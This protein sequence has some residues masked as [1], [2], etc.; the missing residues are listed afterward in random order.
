MKD[1][2]TTHETKR[3]VRRHHRLR[4]IEHARFVVRN[5]W[6]FADDEVEHKAPRVHDHLAACSCWMCGNP[7]RYWGERTLQE[8]RIAALPRRGGAGRLEDWD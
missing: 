7:R 5:C 4:M 3:A 6:A 1:D 2:L 8:I